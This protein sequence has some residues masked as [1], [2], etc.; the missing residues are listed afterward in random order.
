MW[1]HI[2]GDAAFAWFCPGESCAG[3]VPDKMWPGEQRDVC[4]QLV[5]GC[6]ADAITVAW[7]QLIPVELAYRAASEFLHSASLPASISW[8]EL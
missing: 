5:G 2:N 1:I 3:F 6:E 7:W 4:F 8:F